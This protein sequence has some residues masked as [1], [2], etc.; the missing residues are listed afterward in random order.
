[1]IEDI[2]KEI[3]GYCPESYYGTYQL[4]ELDYWGSILDKLTEYIKP[5]MK[6]IDLGGAY[7][8]LSLYCHKL[9]ADVT[10]LDIAQCDTAIEVLKRYPEIKYYGCDL[11]KDC[12]PE[13]QFDIIIATEVFEHL[14]NTDN[15]I[16]EVGKHLK[17]KLFLSTPDKNSTWGDKMESCGHFRHYTVDEMKELFKDFK[18]D[19]HS[20]NVKYSPTN[21]HIDL[22]AERK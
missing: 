10:L 18:L 19:I 8:S 22:I 7:G 5:G 3:L 21:K 14:D 17:G 6:V 2:Q 12:L 4:Y 16:S 1:M 9:G 11:E 15:F 13:G 20:H